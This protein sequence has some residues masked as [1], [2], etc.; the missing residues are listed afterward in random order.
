MAIKIDLEKAYDRVSWEFIE[1]SLRAVGIPDYLNNVIM[2]S[3]SNST[4]QVMWNGTPLSK[5]KP[6]KGVRQ[7]CPLSSYLFVL[8]MEWLGHLIKSAISKDDLVIFSKA[9]IRHCEVLK[10]FLE[11]FCALSGHRINA[12]KTNIFFSKGVDDN[13][14]NSIST[15]FGFQSVHNLGYYLGVLLFHQRVTSSTLQFVVEKVRSKL[16]SYEARKLSFAGRITLAQSV[17][18]SIPSYFMQSM[19][20]PRKTCDDIESLVKQFIW[21]PS[22]RKRKMSLVNWDTICQPKMC[23]GLGLR[24]LKDQNISF[25]MKLGFKLVLDKEAFWN[26]LSEEVI[27]AIKDITS[28]HYFEGSDRISWIHSSSGVFSVKSAYTALKERDWSPKDEK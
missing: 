20:I 4:M 2:S 9:D 26:W 11:D 13:M 16:Q 12:K 1:A 19:M 28:P 23:V 24:K 15:V 25:L 6:V 21:G 5:F 7:G 18:L 22:K 14:V 10:T 27:Q 8:C 3:I 17:F